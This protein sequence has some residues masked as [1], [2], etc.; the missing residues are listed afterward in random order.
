MCSVMMEIDD[1]RVIMFISS[2]GERKMLQI[3]IRLTRRAN[4]QEMPRHVLVNKEGTM[5]D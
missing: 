2:G 4:K 3:V 5:Q 1:R